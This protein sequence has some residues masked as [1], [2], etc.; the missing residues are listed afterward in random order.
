MPQTLRLIESDGHE[1]ENTMTKLGSAV[2]VL[3][4]FDEDKAKEFYVDF[5]GFSIDWQHRFGDNFPVYMQVSKGDCLHP[6]NRMGDQRYVDQGPIR[7]QIDVL[8][9]AVEGRKRT[10]G[11]LAGRDAGDITLVCPPLC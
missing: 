1:L 8:R 7:E 6:G 5:L 4:I 11:R 9:A 10:G 2:P 3:R